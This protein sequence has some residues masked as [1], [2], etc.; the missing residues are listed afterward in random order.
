GLASGAALPAAA[1]AAPAPARL[2]GGIRG[3][4]HRSRFCREAQRSARRF[5][6]A[7]AQLPRVLAYLGSE[8]SSRR[9]F[10]PRAGLTFRHAGRAAA[11]RAELSEFD[12]GRR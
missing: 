10:V 4:V 1:P 3:R 6:P 11:W 5:V 2:E 7:R 9:G 8:L 12:G